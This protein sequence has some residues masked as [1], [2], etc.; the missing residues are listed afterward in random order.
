MDGFSIRVFMGREQQWKSKVVQ[1]SSRW[2]RS[3]NGSKD[4][5]EK[6]E[7]NSMTSNKSRMYKLTNDRSYKE[8]LL[9][10][11]SFL[12]RSSEEHQILEKGSLPSQARKET[13]FD[14]LYLS[15]PKEDVI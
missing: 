1:A 2:R 5:L 11:D 8:V 14:P 12:C 13:N 4:V 10:K 9:S 7:N 15:L 3:T 6:K